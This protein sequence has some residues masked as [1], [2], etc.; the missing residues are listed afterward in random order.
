M[1]EK[2]QV[3]DIKLNK[4]TA[5]E[6]FK[7]AVEYMN[8]ESLQVVLRV[9][10]DTFKKLSNQ[11]ELKEELNQFELLYAGDKEILQAV[12]IKDERLIRETENALFMRMFARYLNMNREKVFVIADTAKELEQMV[13]FMGER[14]KRIQVIE[15]ASFEEHGESEDLILNRINGAGVSCV[16]S[17]LSSPR[18]VEFLAR[19]KALLNARVWFGVGPQWNKWR[20]VSRFSKLKSALAETLLKKTIDK[21]RNN[22]M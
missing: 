10:L 7:R 15:T 19:N 13:G 5:K 6:A 14:Y 18:H 16:V 20:Q 8:T 22:M 9:T 11:A 1:G 4:L 17:L 3:L 21:N 2:I 12:E